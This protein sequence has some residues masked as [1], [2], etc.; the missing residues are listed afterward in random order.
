MRT[1]AELDRHRESILVMLDEAYAYLGRELSP[2]TSFP[3]LGDLE[4][5]EL[6][7]IDR[8][9]RLHRNDPARGRFA[10]VT[11]DL[12][13]YLREAP[14]TLADRA[15]SLLIRAIAMVGVWSGIRVDDDP[16]SMIALQAIGGWKTFGLMTERDLPFRKRE[17]ISAYVAALKVPPPESMI[18]R[19]LPG[20]NTDGRVTLISADLSRVDSNEALLVL[21]RREPSPSNVLRLNSLASESG[22]LRDDANRASKS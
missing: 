14:E 8:A 9:I 20:V 21:D 3:M 7:D 22:V 16:S 2:A 13:A 19:F 4:C 6:A 15:W 10:P 18:P 11:A 12:M 5:F 1:E 17:F